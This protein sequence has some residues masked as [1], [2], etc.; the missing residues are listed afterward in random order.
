LLGLSIAAP[1]GPIMAIMATASVQGR[2]RESIRTAFGAASGD[3]L[4]FLLVAL[5]FVT[6]LAAYPRIVGFLGIVGGVMLLGMAWSGLRAARRGL[7]SSS[8]RGSYRLGL[9]TALTSPFSFAWWMASGPL[10]IATLGWPGAVGL[11]SSI[12]AYSVTFTLALRWLGARVRHTALIVAYVG[13]FLLAVFGIVFVREGTRLLS[14][15]S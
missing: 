6:V 10:V 8:V 13:A 3:A 1:P 9:L 12:L 2:I 4:W 15:P 7:G 5:G 14:G 11:F